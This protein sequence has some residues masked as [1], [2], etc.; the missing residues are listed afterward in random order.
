M[1]TLY[2]EKVYQRSAAWRQGTPQH[3]AGVNYVLEDGRRRAGRGRPQGSLGTLG[4]SEGA[5][6][7]ALSEPVKRVPSGPS[8]GSQ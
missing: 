5:R 1:D 3:V 7:D 2:H 6:R 4:G 8:T